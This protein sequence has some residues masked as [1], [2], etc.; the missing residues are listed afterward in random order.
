VT[1]PV[2]ITSADVAS[3]PVTLRPPARTGA[4]YRRARVLVRSG[5]VPLEFVECALAAGG[6]V[7]DTRP[8]TA[9]DL[10]APRLAG[11][12]SVIVCTRDRPEQL[13]ACL[14]AMR[15]L[16]DDDVEL[17]VVDNSAAATATG[18]F[19]AA[20]GDDERFRLVHEPRPGLSRARNRGLAEATGTVVAFT[21][22]DVRVDA[23]WLDGLRLGFGDDPE[24]ACVT[25]LVPA[26]ELEHPMQE[27][28][29]AKVSWSSS[30]ER[31]RY[32]MATDR[33]G[34][35][36]YD[37]GRFG[38][39]ANFAVRTEVLRGLGGFDL[40]LGAGS[41]TR[42]GEDLDVFAR[43]VLAGHALVYEP[44]AIAWHVHRATSDELARQV[45]GYGVGLSAYLT[46]LLAG[47]MRG[48]VLRRVVS[49]AVV[50]GRDKRGERSAGLPPSLLA[51]ELAGCVVGPFAYWRARREARRC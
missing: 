41:R 19:A 18:A 30:L 32:S 36:P 31:R 26:A 5:R 46:K 10:D 37:A 40:A 22:D 51:R 48:D 16:V 3:G 2:W 50:F 33:T 44:R 29:D 7:V 12:I 21:D 43:V 1:G 25:G 20:V 35:F 38:T 13:S 39:G 23:W 45:F 6:V 47:P 4:P 49:G 17:I 24:V 28:F 14:D 27:L 9:D 34:A 42:G 11:R 15:H 8:S